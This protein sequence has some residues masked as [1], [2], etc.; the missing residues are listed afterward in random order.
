MVPLLMGR[1]G[2]RGCQ[3]DDGAM[4]QDGHDGNN[5]LDP[6]MESDMYVV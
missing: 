3:K 5:L 4:K 6:S 2:L 1:S